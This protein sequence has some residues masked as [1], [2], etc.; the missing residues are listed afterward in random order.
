MSQLKKQAQDSGPRIP[1]AVSDP[2]LK[3]DI[4]RLRAA[5]KADAA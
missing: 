3:K 4:Q 1:A 2:P 5:S